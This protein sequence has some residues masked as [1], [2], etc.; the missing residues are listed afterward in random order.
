MSFAGMSIP[1]QR[2][3]ELQESMPASNRWLKFGIAAGICSTATNAAIAEITMKAGPECLLYFA[4]GSIFMG[5]IYFS[6]MGYKN[7]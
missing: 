7:N 6:Y 1:S 5:I 2:N 3:T 4:S